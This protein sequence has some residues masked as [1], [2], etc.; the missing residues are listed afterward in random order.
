MKQCIKCTRWYEDTASDIC[1]HM[2]PVQRDPLLVER[3][4]THGDWRDTAAKAQALKETL[5]FNKLSRLEVYNEALDMI[6][7]KLARIICGNEKTK[8]HW[9]DIAGYAK[10]GAEACDE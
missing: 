5:A 4:K 1:P 6:A 9:L 7:T 3:E 2:F 8:D 10:L